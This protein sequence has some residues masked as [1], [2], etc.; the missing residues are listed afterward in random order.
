MRALYRWGWGC[1]LLTLA[2]PAAQAQFGAAGQL[3]PAT[4][5]WEQAANQVWW[6]DPLLEM[7]RLPVVQW[8]IA[9]PKGDLLMLNT[10]TGDVAWQVEL[11]AP[12]ESMAASGEFLAIAT[13]KAIG[14]LNVTDGKVVWG[15]PIAAGLDRGWRKEP[16]FPEPYWAGAPREPVQCVGGGL[17]RA[18]SSGSIPTT[19]SSAAGWR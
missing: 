19:C 17:M 16:D 8:P 13:S 3:T 11:Q 12:I 1:V 2:A 5:A 9:A 4:V 7:E 10:R 14:V 15:Q 18:R 6:L